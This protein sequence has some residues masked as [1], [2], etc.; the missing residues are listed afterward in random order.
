M[1][2]CSYQIVA[3]DHGGRLCWKVDDSL[4]WGPRKNSHVNKRSWIASLFEGEKQSYTTSGPTCPQDS[5][6]MHPFFS[7]VKWHEHCQWAGEKCTPYHM[8]FPKAMSFMSFTCCSMWG[9]CWDCWGWYG[10]CGLWGS[11]Y[12]GCRSC[13]V[14][15][16]CSLNS[17]ADMLVVTEVFRVL[18][19]VVALWTS[20]QSI[21]WLFNIES[22]H[23]NLDQGVTWSIK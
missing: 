13:C 4:G 15:G 3:H 8:V 9:N 16:S 18:V 5:L 6:L 10:S 19:T 11:I 21:F 12:T 23:L 14:C 22:A 2:N 20:K 17:L 7:R 1:S